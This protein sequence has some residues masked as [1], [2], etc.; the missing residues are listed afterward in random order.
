LCLSSLSLTN[1]KVRHRYAAQGSFGWN[2]LKLVA[3]TGDYWVGAG[4]SR[5]SYDEYTTSTSLTCTYDQ[6]SVTAKVR[7]PQRL[8]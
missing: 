8:A 4:R 2:A 3:S 7:R 6:S 5:D 1:T